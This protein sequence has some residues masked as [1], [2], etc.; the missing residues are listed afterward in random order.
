[1][2]EYL[3]EIKIDEEIADSYTMEDMQDVLEM[4]DIEH[5]TEVTTYKDYYYLESDVLTV[6]VYED[7][8]EI[9]SR[10][11]SIKLLNDIRFDL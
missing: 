1:M 2:K 5:L 4:V 6:T 11:Y 10:T 3:V 9:Y 7:D 8:Y